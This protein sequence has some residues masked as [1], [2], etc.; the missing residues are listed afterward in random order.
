MNTSTYKVTA[1]DGATSPVIDGSSVSII[2]SS[3][4]STHKMA[5]VNES[6]L[7]GY[8]DNCYSSSQC[9]SYNNQCCFNSYSYLYDQCTYSYDCYTNSAYTYG[10]YY[11]PSGASIASII[12]S[13]TFCV[14][15]WIA[16][17]CIVRRRRIYYAR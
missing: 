11:G 6:T 14:A 3:Y 5:S 16:V 9:T 13:I 4:E 12:S 1:D 7:A 2:G 17:A 15:F 8:L 10:Y